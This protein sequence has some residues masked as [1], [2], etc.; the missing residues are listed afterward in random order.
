VE[1]AAIL[2]KI[3]FLG[4]SSL[5]GLNSFLEWGP[6]AK[7]QEKPHGFLLVLEAKKKA[8]PI[9]SFQGAAAPG[10]RFKKEHIAY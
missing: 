2:N 3:I 6:G 4:L 1:H 9:I 7:P 10:P 8:E 5:G